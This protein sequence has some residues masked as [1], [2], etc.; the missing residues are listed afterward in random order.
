MPDNTLIGEFVDYPCYLHLCPENY[1][2]AV[3]GKMSMIVVSL[4][5]A[6]E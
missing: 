1:F 6:T 5:E 4:I 2:S 3:K